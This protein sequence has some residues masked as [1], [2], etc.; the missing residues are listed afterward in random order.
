MKLKNIYRGGI[1]ENYKKLI[2][3]LEIPLNKLDKKKT[4]L[5]IK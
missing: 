2:K 3:K 4:R 1:V 5:I